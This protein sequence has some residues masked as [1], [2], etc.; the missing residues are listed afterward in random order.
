T[1]NLTPATTSSVTADNADGSREVFRYDIAAQKI[2][3][4]TFSA[5]TGS[6]LEQTVDGQAYI[7][8]S[9]ASI[10][11]SFFAT[12]LA[13]NAAAI[14]DLFQAVIV[15][16][17]GAGSVAPKIANAANFDGTQ[18]A[19]GS[20]VAAFGSQLANATTSTPTG[21]LPYD[22]G[23]VTVL[24]NGLAARLIFVSPG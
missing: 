10:V 13:P 7:D 24:V 18:A 14:E 17:T 16:V 20:L 19:R 3:Q 5:V 9:G 21:D 6:T 23:G 11:F 2:R 22:L 15:P 4:V 1:A 8:N 12:Q